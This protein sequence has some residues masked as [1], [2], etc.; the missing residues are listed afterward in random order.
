MNR[1][2]MLWATLLLWLGACSEP[3]QLPRRHGFHRIEL[4]AETQQIRFESEACPF[5][6]SYPAGGRITRDR[7]DSCWADINFP[8]Y[9][10][11][12]HMTCR[13]V[14]GAKLS[15]AEMFEEHRRL[16]YKHAKKA[17]DIRTG[18]FDIPA[19]RVIVH[20]VYGNVGAP[21]YYFV[22]DSN[23]Q[24]VLTLTFYFQT[25]LKNDS[26]APVIDYMKAEVG[27]SLM[28]LQWQ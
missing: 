18:E 21:A 28:S 11:K 8:R 26:L 12:W 3:E 27:R 4:P 10:L 16:I 25:A 19:G 22:S 23:R 5:T 17:T 15:Y 9:E 1:D 20:E 13:P 14:G 7:S 24:N 6:F 2:I